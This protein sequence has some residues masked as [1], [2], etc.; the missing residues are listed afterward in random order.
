[1]KSKVLFSLENRLQH[2]FRHE[3]ILF[4]FFIPLLAQLVETHNGW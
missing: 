2:G 1:M 4:V 3:F